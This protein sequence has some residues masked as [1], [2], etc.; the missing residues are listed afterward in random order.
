MEQPAHET[1]APDEQ[2]EAVSGDRMETPNHPDDHNFDQPNGPNGCSPGR[3]N[4]TPKNPEPEPEPELESSSLLENLPAELRDHILFSM[5]DL[6]TLQTLVRASPMMHAQY[7]S[8][9]NAILGAAVARELDGFLVDAYACAM[10]RR[11]AIG[12]PRTKEKII[13]HL[14]AYRGW[15][16]GSQIDVDAIRPSYVRWLSAFHL[17]II[18][19]MAHQYSTWALQNLSRATSPAQDQGTVETPAVPQPDVALSRSEEIRIFQALY[20]YETYYHLFGFKSLAERQD[21]LHLNEINNNF[22]GLFNPWEGEAVGCIDIFIR[23]RYHQIFDDVQDDLHAANPDLDFRDDTKH[24]EGSIYACTQR[25]DSIDGAVARGLRPTIDVFTTE[26]RETLVAKVHKY[27]RPSVL[28]DDPIRR[29]LLPAVQA[30]R[31]ST[32]PD[33]RDEAERRK[34]VMEFAG[35]A[36]PPNGPPLG[37]VLL[38]NGTYVNI[39]GEHVPPTVQKWGYVMWDER[40]WSELEAKTLVLKQWETEPDRIKDIEIFYGWKPSGF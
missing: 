11:H 19:P 4:E 6:L 26:D 7:R 14:D 28:L 10:S 30:Q 25:E 24:N 3:G 13:A 37:W 35:D 20:R 15:M 22:F 36:V 5:P 17:D 23:Q 40:R 21:I 33:A 1:I 34:D 27:I 8:N 29:T 12:K 9:R 2:R 38:W 16:S 32:H 18:K 31:R 39:Y